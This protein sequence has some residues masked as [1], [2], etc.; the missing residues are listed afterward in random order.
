MDDE[1]AA[2]PLAKVI[3]L[4]SSAGNSPVAASPMGGLAVAGPPSSTSASGPAPAPAHATAPVPQSIP[5]SVP[6]PALS[7]EAS[8]TATQTPK[9]PAPAGAAEP[10]SATEPVTST[11]DNA[12]ATVNSEEP[13]Q[14]TMETDTTPNPSGTDFNLSPMA[15]FNMDD[16]DGFDFGPPPAGLDLS[17]LDF[18]NSTQPN[19]ARGSFDFTSLMSDFNS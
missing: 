14:D 6:R 1:D 12:N 19:S 2:P 5:A 9:V 17:Q 13:K 8:T 10:P 4:A 11:A 3:N 18:G 15:D 7:T 16:L